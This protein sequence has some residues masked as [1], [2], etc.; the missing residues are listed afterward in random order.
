MMDKPSDVRVRAAK[1]GA[2]VQKKL[3]ADEVISLRAERERGA[4]YVDLVEKYGISKSTVSF[5]VNR[6]TYADIR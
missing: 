1:A 4:K 6:K 2:D 5:I 3:T